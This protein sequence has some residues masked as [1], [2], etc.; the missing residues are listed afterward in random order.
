VRPTVSCGRTR[1]EWP[2]PPGVEGVSE[3]AGATLERIDAELR[4]SDTG[5]LAKAERRS[6]EA[7]RE[8]AVW[9]GVLD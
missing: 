4:L 8:L 2:H 9:M 6:C 3:P 1:R 7:L 5:A